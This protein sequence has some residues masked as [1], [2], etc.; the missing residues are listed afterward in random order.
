[1]RKRIIIFAGIAFLCAA[2]YGWYLYNK[3]HSSVQ[4]IP[5]DI[6]ITADDLY[7][8]YQQNEASADKKFLDKV[9]EVNGT[10]DDIQQTDSTLSIRLDAGAAMG[11]INCSIT[12]NKTEKQIVPQ[13]KSAVIIKGKC[14][15]FL[16]DVNLVDCVLVNK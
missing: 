1:M 3:P 10:V 15:G 4:D 8:H 7:Q 16:M 12:F 6:T 13:K 2:L 9:I 14:A 11:G 5:A